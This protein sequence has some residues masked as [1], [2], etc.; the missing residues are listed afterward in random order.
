MLGNSESLVQRMLSE[1]YA[2]ST[3]EFGIGKRDFERWLSSETGSAAMNE[4]DG[5]TTH[6]CVADAEGNVVSLTQSI[7]SLFG[8]KVANE[9]L[10]FIY[11]NY[12]STCPRTQ[13]PHQL[14]SRSMPR[15]NVPTFVFQGSQA[16]KFPFLVLGAA[17]SRRIPSSI[18]QTISGVLDWKLE[19]DCAIW[20][21]A[22]TL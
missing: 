9:Q 22:S 20:A 5:E 19:V 21:P 10:G 2:D 7:Q 16:G 12:L 11:N 17:G 1:T 6:L 8:T 4:S 13:H 3:S 18:L 14:G 15:S